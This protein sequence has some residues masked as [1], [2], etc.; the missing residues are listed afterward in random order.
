MAGMQVRVI[1]EPS[2]AIEQMQMSTTCPARIV[3]LLGSVGHGVMTYE[4]D[5]PIYLIC[6]G[7]VTRVRWLLKY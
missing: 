3:S 6:E 1:A 7:M 5:L 2:S 4:S